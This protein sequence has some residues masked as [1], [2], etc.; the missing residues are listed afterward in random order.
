MGDKQTFQLTGS[1]LQ[2]ILTKHGRDAVKKVGNDGTLYEV[3]IDLVN[4]AYAAER[5]AKFEAL[6]PS[7]A[8]RRDDLGH[9][10][11]VE[12]DDDGDT[13]DDGDSK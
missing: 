1:V 10:F 9:S 3:D 8:D 5:G 6:G 4:E 12:V 7:N 13:K 11:E 2:F